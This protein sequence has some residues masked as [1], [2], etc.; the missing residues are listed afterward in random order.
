[1]NLLIFLENEFFQNFYNFEYL[2]FGFFK[3]V[4]M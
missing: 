2:V 1:M 4:A 3:A